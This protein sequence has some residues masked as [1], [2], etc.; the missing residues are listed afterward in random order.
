MK[1]IICLLVVIS[2]LFTGCNQNKPVSESSASNTEES[3]IESS[4]VAQTENEAKEL[5]EMDGNENFL[6][7]LTEEEKKEDFEYFWQTVRDNYPFWGVASRKGID[8]NEIENEYK[9]KLPEAETDQEFVNLMWDMSYEFERIGH[10]MMMEDHAI[11]K[12]YCES[13]KFASDEPHCKY[14]YDILSNPTSAE[15]YAR[16]GKIEA[17]IQ[18]DDYKPYEPTDNI[19]DYEVESQVTTKIL[20]EG[21][22]AYA[23]IESFDAM[24]IEKDE[25]ILSNF[26][27]EVADYENLI[28]DI[29]GNGGGSDNYWNQNFVNLLLK[30][31]VHEK[32]YML[33]SNTPIISSYIASA[34]FIDKTEPIENLPALPK[35]QEK[36]KELFDKF[37]VQD[38]SFETFGKP[39]FKG[40]IWVL[41][42]EYVYSSSESFSMFCKATGF[43]TLVGTQTGGDGGGMDPL[44]FSM[45]NSGLL[46]RNSIL[47]TLNPDGSNS[48]E[49]GTTPDIISPS[50]E[51]PLDTCLKAIAE[52]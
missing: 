20:E 1:R 7:H 38:V 25:E 41:V 5:K 30:E 17:D 9:E 16:L 33:Y 36:D 52:E 34:S 11:Y 32:L 26:Y 8:L 46:W 31:S 10:F 23:R 47:Y 3:K 43:A 51:A 40:K 28:I 27:K 48:E 12:D 14:I 6:G 29:T 4:A 39:D 45:P 50:G 13:Y 21:K 44:I 49:T 19:E 2:L 18:G 15:C 35:L 37:I 24:A 42:D 22:I